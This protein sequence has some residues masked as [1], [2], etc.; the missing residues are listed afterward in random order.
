MICKVLASC[1]LPLGPYV[2]RPALSIVPAW[3]QAKDSLFDSV[4]SFS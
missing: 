1:P 2:S 4:G 3:S